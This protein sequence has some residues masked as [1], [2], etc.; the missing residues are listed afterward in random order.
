[1]TQL[2]YRGV[3]YI[4]EEEHKAFSQWWRWVHRPVVWL[5]YRGIKYRPCQIDKSVWQ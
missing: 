2:V 5:V 3:A 1:M 4:A